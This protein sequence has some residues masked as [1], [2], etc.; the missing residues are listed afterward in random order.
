MLHKVDQR[1]RGSL[2][3]LNSGGESI[4][5]EAASDPSALGS[6]SRCVSAGSFEPLSAHP[7]I[8]MSAG[9]AALDS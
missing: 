1:H 4:T 5:T 3:H 7:E 8:L 2:P 9:T 6:R